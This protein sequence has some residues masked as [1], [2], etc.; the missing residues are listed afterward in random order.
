MKEYKNVPL[1]ISCPNACVTHGMHSGPDEYHTLIPILGKDPQTRKVEIMVL[2][3]WKCKFEAWASKEYRD[4]IGKPD[5]PY[6]DSESNSII[7]KA[8]GED[9]K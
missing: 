1:Q 2:K 3:C 4:A 9:E 7:S 5:Q 6:W 8:L